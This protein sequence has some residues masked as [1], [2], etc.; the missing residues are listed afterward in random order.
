MAKTTT[1]NY[2]S[3][4]A[5]GNTFN[6]RISADSD[7]PDRNDID[8]LGAALEEHDHASGKGAAVARVTTACLATWTVV[9][10]VAGDSPYTATTSD[11]VILC[12]ATAGAIT[13]NLPTAVG[14]TGRTYHIK[15]T[16][17]S[18]NAVTIDPNGSETVD[19]S[20]TKAINVQYTS[21]TVVSDGTN[22]H[23]V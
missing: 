5:P 4:A 6:K 13:V 22:W 12:N 2:T 1:T 11:Q 19:G 15:K 9:S 8:A 20:S 23:I 10:K 21:Y 3:C 17:S 18:A 7:P 14:I 16:D